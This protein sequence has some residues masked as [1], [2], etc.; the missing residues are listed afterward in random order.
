MSDLRKIVI[1]GKEIETDGAMTLIQA[2][3][4]AGIEIPFPHRVQI[5]KK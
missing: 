5:Q 4:Q 1:D 3:E 2:C